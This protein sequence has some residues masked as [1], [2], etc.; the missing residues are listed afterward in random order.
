MAAAARCLRSLPR[1]TN[2]AKHISSCLAKNA[3]QRSSRSTL[4]PLLKSF[5]STDSGLLKGTG[6]VGMSSRINFS[7]RLVPVSFVCSIPKACPLSI[8]A[9]CEGSDALDGNLGDDDG[10]TWSHGNDD[11]PYLDDT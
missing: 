11:D 7:K 5:L 9:G 3:S 2:A 8:D 4:S 6:I 1:S 10:D